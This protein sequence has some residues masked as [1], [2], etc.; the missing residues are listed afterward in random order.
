MN[1]VPIC[2]KLQNFF[3]GNCYLTALGTSHEVKEVRPNSV[4]GKNI[5]SPLQNV[6]TKKCCLTKQ[7]ILI[8]H[9]ILQAS[10]KVMD[11]DNLEWS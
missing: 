6:N 11:Y 9:F 4:P 1:V 8:K 7:Y 2:N 10:K 3:Q 5:E